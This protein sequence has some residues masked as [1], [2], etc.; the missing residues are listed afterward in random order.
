MGQEIIG[1]KSEGGVRAA[2]LDSVLLFLNNHNIK[3]IYSVVTKYRAEYQSV[4][5][6]IVSVMIAS[7][8][9][10]CCEYNT[11][12]EKTIINEARNL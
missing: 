8:A 6:R 3:V 1:F 9:V 11:D 12:Y 2:S 4:F 5:S 7:Q 10:I